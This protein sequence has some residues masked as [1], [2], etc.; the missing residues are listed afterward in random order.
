MANKRIAY[1][2]YIKAI[3]CIFVVLQHVATYGYI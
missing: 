3:A 1:L 2:D